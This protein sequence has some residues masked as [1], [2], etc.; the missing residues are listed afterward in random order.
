[1]SSS[2]PT[3]GFGVVLFRSVQGALGAEK[4]LVSAGVPHKLIAVPRH[5]SSSCGF[6]LRFP[7]ADRQRVEEL[8]PGDRLGVESIVALNRV[9]EAGRRE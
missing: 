1:L 5:L 9:D 4:L 7:W 6:C 8:L 3:G 2:E